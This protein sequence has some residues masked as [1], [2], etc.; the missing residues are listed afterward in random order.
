MKTITKRPKCV[1]L[2]LA[3]ILMIVVSCSSNEKS[4]ITS[5]ETG[6]HKLQIDNTNSPGEDI[7]FVVVEKMPKFPGGDTALL[8]FLSKNVRYPEKPKTNNI[9]GRVIVRFCVTPKGGISQVSILKGVDPELD[10]EA[11]RI[12]SSLPNFEP[13]YQSGK[14]VPVWY[15]VPVTFTLK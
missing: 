5:D 13:G 4:P 11:I 9:Q 7:P 10:A 8:E 15:M 3:A 2:L 12:V 1:P 14:P 6:Q